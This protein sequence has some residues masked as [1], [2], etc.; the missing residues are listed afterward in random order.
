MVARVIKK[1]LYRICA[2]LRAVLFFFLSKSC[3]LPIT[4]PFFKTQI[5]YD[6]KNRSFFSL[7]TRDWVDW[8]SIN[9]IFYHGCYAVDQ[10]TRKDDMFN[11]YNGILGKNKFPLI[12]DCG[13]NIGIGT[14]YFQLAFPESKIVSIEPDKENLY[15]AKLNNQNKNV[16]FKA[17]GVGAKD[18]I[19]RLIDPGLG[20]NA[21][22]IE[23]DQ[24]GDIKIESINSIL[25]EYSE[26]VP[27]LIKI[28]I[29]GFER[30]LFSDNLEWIDKFPVLI[31]ELHDWL[32]PREGQSLNFLREISKRNRDFVFIG[33][34]VFSI[35]NTLSMLNKNIE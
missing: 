26:Y 29:E 9:Q 7:K 22:R 35:D 21:Y 5:F 13:A 15:F 4:P 2:W 28:D 25:A 12:L 27:F 24:S 31:I 10:L 1:N 3:F 32:F 19:G 8:T 23:Y 30:D 14:R 18:I 17:V 11:V 20:A 6:R 34:N 16:F 33:E